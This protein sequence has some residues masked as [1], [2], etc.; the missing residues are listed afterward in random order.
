MQVAAEYMSG[1]YI[2]PTGPLTVSLRLAA[3]PRAVTLYPEKRPLQG[4]Y[5]NG[6]W[7]GTVPRLEIH[8]IVA[9]A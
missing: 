9:F 4:T 5:A 6:V 7:R 3:K 1:D 2:P 8:A